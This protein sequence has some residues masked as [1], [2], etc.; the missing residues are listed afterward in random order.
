MG[1]ESVN[2]V[3]SIRATVPWPLSRFPSVSRG[4]QVLSH[5]V[6]E[7]ILQI[8]AE[9]VPGWILSHGGPFI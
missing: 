8:L 7:V 6:D 1:G 9:D 4:S 3:D 5:K 2:C